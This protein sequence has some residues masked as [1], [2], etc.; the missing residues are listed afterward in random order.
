MIRRRGLA[1]ASAGMSG[2]LLPVTRLAT[3]GGGGGGGDE[4]PTL[5]TIAALDPFPLPVEKPKSVSMFL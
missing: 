3:A 4:A 5:V 2:A 1:A